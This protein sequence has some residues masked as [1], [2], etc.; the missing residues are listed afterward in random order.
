MIQLIFVLIGAFQSADN[1]LVMTGGPDYATHV[2]GL[3][4]FYNAYVYL[5]FG[6]AIAIAWIL[7]FFLIGLTMF[8][9]KRILQMNFTTAEASNMPIILKSEKRQSRTRIVHIV[10]YTMLA[11][12]AVTMVYPFLL[13]TSGSFKSKVDVQDLSI[14]PKYF[15]K[16]EVLF[17]KYVEAKYNESIAE[18]SSATGDEVQNFRA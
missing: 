12:G 5:R 15:Y 18:Y 9:M 11:L 4:I 1:V 6:V 17:K 10:L 3:E 14:I 16:D 2:I 8:Q 7:G 13:M